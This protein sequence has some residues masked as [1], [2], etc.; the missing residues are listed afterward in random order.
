MMKGNP[1]FDRIEA[2]E[3]SK[4]LALFDFDGTITAKDSLA[5]FV[6][7]AAGRFNYYSGLLR[8]SPILLSYKLKLISNSRAKERLIGHFFYDYPVDDFRRTAE[9]Y[10]LEHLER[11]VRPKALERIKWHQ[12]RGHKVVVVSAS[13]ECWLK[14]WC[15]RHGIE[16][17][18]TRL[19]VKNNKLTGEFSTKNCH[20]KEKVN[21]IKSKYKL[22]EYEVIYAYGDS[23]GDRDM[24]KIAHKRYY[25]YFH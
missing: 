7:F 20:G 15:E 4:G 6:K 24:L 22:S 12:R 1:I 21:R 8:L 16:L 23:P 9:H 17:I 14:G 5:E 19:E 3:K 25:R 10:S 2:C 13:M 18:A 11:I